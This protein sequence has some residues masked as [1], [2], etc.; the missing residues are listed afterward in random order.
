MDKVNKLQAENAQQSERIEELEGM[1]AAN[2]AMAVSQN[3]AITELYTQLQLSA[4]V[5]EAASNCVHGH[6]FDC[7]M[8]R[9]GRR[10]PNCICGFDTFTKALASFDTPDVGEKK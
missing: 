3:N 8:Q 10:K 6:T 4:G 7:A 5:I 1:D 2:K 9:N